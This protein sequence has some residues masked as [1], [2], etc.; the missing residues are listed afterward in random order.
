[1]SYYQ[2]LSE[3]YNGALITL[4]ESHL[5]DDIISAEIEMTGYQV[6][7][8]DRTDRKGGGVVTYIREDL[9]VTNVKE[10]SNNYCEYL[11]CYLPGLK[12]ALVTIYRPPSCPTSKFKEAIDGINT[13]LEVFEKHGQLFPNLIINGDLNL[14]SMNYWEPHDIN[15]LRDRALTRTLSIDNKQALLL[16]ELVDQHMMQQLITEPTRGDAILDLLFSNN[17]ELLSKITII[18][19]IIISDHKTIVAGINII[20][21]QTTAKPATNFSASTLP[22]YNF[23]LATESEWKVIRHNLTQFNWT[24]FRQSTNSDDLLDNLLEALV[25]STSSVLTKRSEFKL[26]TSRGKPFSSKNWIPREV[27]TLLRRKLQASKKLREASTPARC[28]KLRD[29]LLKTEAE[30]RDSHRLKKLTEEQS[31]WREMKSNPNAF[32]KYVKKLKNVTSRIGPFVDPSGEPLLA[33]EADYLNSQ[34][35]KV[36]SVPVEEMKIMDPAQFFGMDRESSPGSPGALGGGKPPSQPPGGPGGTP[37]GITEVP[38]SGTEAIPSPVQDMSTTEP[39]LFSE[40]DRDSRPGSPGALGGGKSPSQPPGGPGGT[41]PGITEVPQSGTEAIS[42]PAQ[43]MST[44]DPTLFSEKDRESSPGSPGALGGGKSPSQPPGGPGGTPP[45]AAEVPQ[46][47]TVTDFI[48][49]PSDINSA[50]R[51]QAAHSCPGPDGIPPILIKKCLPE[52]QEHLLTLFQH[53][54]DTG[55]VPRLFRTAFVKPALKAGKNKALPSSFRPLSM[56]SVLSKCLERILRKLLQDHLERNGLLS[57]SQH[58]FRKGRS[59]LTQ[60][61]DHYD[62]VL[63]ALETGANC[64]S[65]Y[66][67]FA[68]AFDKVDIA[69][70]LRRLKDKNITGKVARWIHSWLSGRTQ[71][72]VAN[73]DISISSE[74]TSGVPQGSVLGPLLFLVMIDSI[75][76]CDTSSWISIFADDSRVAN[77]VKNIADAEALQEDLEKIYSWQRSSNSE[78]NVDKFEV[79]QYGPNQE[80]KMTYN[81]LT[82]DA[83]DVIE[84]KDATKDLGVIMAASGKFDLHITAVSNKVRGL[85]GW[86]RRTF[87]SRKFLFMKFFW[88]TYIVPHLDY[89][90]QLWSPGS[91]SPNL[92]KLEGLLRTFTTWFP[93]TEGMSYWERLRYIKMY[94]I[95]QRF[96]RYKTLFTWK[97]LEGKVPNCGLTWKTSPLVGRLCTLPQTKQSSSIRTLRNNSFQ[98]V[99]PRLFNSFPSSVRNYSGSSEGLKKL[100][101]AHLQTIPDHPVVTGGQLP[102]PINCQTAVNTNSIIDWSRL[103]YPGIRRQG[104]DVFNILDVSIFD[105]QPDVSV[106]L[107]VSVFANQTDVS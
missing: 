23:D 97:I 107:D 56:T 9:S 19:N 80:L 53:S 83:T 55:D 106:I 47:D 60:L 51:E 48:I 16:L 36:F 43:D 90:S 41:P 31:A 10:F 39:T 68:K 7:R 105:N 87:I 64:D 44:T 42:A 2:S 75:T 6:L 72:V 38:Q 63:K 100:V 25:S 5:K 33:T 89:A 24:K 102:V 11:A 65:V 50:M 1:V 74:V 30:L 52:L 94:S 13:W 86:F 14:K 40:M 26:L 34:F 3:L 4:T 101:D 57:D 37:P 73:G 49:S 15:N 20:V 78:F 35:L 98:A 12:T 45:E 85:M 67:D 93:G 32:Y 17:Q 69:I 77:Q 54:L 22:E 76:T 18:E 29:I 66:I 62:R 61:L 95:Q 104:P 59:C 88:T 79:L 91:E 81:Y 103:M 70:L 82:P 28:S 84:A 96:E 8:A 71:Q 46:P 58:G 27:R 92:Q 99:G 21:G